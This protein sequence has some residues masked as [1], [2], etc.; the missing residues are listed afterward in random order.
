MKLLKREREALAELLECGAESSEAL[1]ELAAA[2]ID[3][4]RAERGFQYGVLMV[5]GIGK[6]V[7]PFSTGHQAAKAIEKHGAE[8]A[9]VVGGHTSEGLD[10]HMV[11][12]DEPAPTKGDFAVVH[13]DSLAFKRGWNGKQST[14]GSWG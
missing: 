13:E 3:T 4:L 6:V 9:W 10:L 5:A 8:R 1:A 2:K 11:K 14:R 7:G 12:V